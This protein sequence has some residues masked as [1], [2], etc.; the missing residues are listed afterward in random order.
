VRA[1]ALIAAALAAV[2]VTGGAAGYAGAAFTDDAARS[3]S[4][5]AAA[6][7]FP[8]VVSAVP[9]ILGTAQM[10]VALHATAGTFSPA[11]TSTSIAWLRCDAAGANC[12]STGA[13]GAD[14][15]PV[16]GDTGKTLRA[17]LTPVNGSTPGTAVRS[18]P[19]FSVLGLSLGPVVVSPVLTNTPSI[20]GTAT[21]GQ[22]LT[23]APGSWLQLLSATAYKWQ[24]CDATGAACAPIAGAT[25]QTYTLTAADRGRRLSLVVTV[26]TLGLLSTSAVTATTA[27]VS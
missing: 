11:P 1:R 12:V 10:G 6:T 5:F 16:L 17:E 2:V 23:G 4:T 18:E 9:A 7:E 27:V 13:T 25:S 15:T 20:I 26:S 19:T 14:Y 24:R 3:S 22:T 21:V 8:P